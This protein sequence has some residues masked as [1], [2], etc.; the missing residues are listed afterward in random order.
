MGNSVR[1]DY[2]SVPFHSIPFH[3]TEP[4]SGPIVDGPMDN[5]GAP[6]IPGGEGGDED[7][8]LPE[9]TVGESSGL[10]AVDGPNLGSPEPVSSARGAVYSHFLTC[11]SVVLCSVL[12]TLLRH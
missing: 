12:G 11:L 8:D 6:S 9:N 7:T 3:G 4:G 2:D 1:Q 5:T 10:G